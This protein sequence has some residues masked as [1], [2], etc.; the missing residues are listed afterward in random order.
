MGVID[1]WRVADRG[2]L[3]TKYNYLVWDKVTRVISN[4]QGDNLCG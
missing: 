4:Y 3:I 2:H 1:E